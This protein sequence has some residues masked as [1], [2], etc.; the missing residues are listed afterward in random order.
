VGV[1][2]RGSAV[3]AA[4][5]RPSAQG[6]ARTLVAAAGAATSTTGDLLTRVVIA[7]ARGD[8]LFALVWIL[9]VKGGP[10]QA[11]E[12]GGLGR[13]IQRVGQS[14][15]RLEGLVHGLD[16]GARVVVPIRLQQHRREHVEI[17]LGP[18]LGAGVGIVDQ[19]GPI[20]ARARCDEADRIPVSHP[21]LA[22]AV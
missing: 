4:D 12:P 11:A 8:R 15:T 3:P 16:G 22:E 14:L 1:R 7:I 20:D 18:T 5:S 19:V 2:G 9:G 6:S 13:E 10:W 17:A 21:R